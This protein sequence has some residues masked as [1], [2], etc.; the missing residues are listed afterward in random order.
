[1]R[2]SANQTREHVLAVAHE[3]FYWRGIKNTGVDAVAAAAG[4]APTTLYRL[5]ASKDDLV[6]AYV[7]RAGERYRQWFLD[8]TA[9]A[10]PAEAIRSLFAALAD[11]VRPDRC[12]GCPFLMAMAELPDASARAHA[13]AIGT[14]AW[15]RERIGEL[16]AGLRVADPGTL[17]DQLVLVMEGVYA[18]APALGAD[19]PARQARGLVEALLTTAVSA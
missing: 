5:F 14:K 2:R 15:V 9:G 11:Q 18:S 1:M 19:G 3:L 12:R 10:G 6:A 7:E 17:A 16:T 8:A 4:V 13:L